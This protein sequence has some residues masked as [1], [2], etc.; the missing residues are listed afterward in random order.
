MS[1]CWTPGDC[2]ADEGSLAGDERC[3]RDGLEMSMGESLGGI[4]QSAGARTAMDLGQAHGGE[5]SATC[6]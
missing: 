4:C 1:C 6:L 2:W 3:W 5:A